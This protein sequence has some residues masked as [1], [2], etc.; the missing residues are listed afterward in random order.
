MSP[1]EKLVRKV[2][3]NRC[4]RIAAR[5]GLRVVKPYRLDPRALDFDTWWLTKSYVETPGGRLEGSVDRTGPFRSLDELEG[6]L[7]ADPADRKEA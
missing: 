6:W 7:L 1:D 4:R 2:Q 3:E 5:Q